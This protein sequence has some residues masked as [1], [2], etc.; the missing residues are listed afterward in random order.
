[1]EIQMCAGMEEQGLRLHE[2]RWSE[3]PEEVVPE[4][5]VCEMLGSGIGDTVTFT[6][7]ATRD[8]W[9]LRIVGI[10]ENTATLQS[11]GWTRGYMNVSPSF[12][13]EAGILT[14]ETEEHTLIVT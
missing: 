4:Q 7:G 10:M 13:Y 2:G 12:P 14:P 6:C 5:Y 1:M 11:S 3:S 8:V 9:Q